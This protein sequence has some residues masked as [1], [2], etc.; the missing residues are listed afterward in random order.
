M[1]RGY[2]KLWRSCTDDDLYFLEPFTKWQAWIDLLILANHKPGMISVR[3]NL[4]QVDSGQVAVSE[5][6]VSK[7]WRW[8]RNK[9]RRFAKLLEKQGKMKQ[10]KSNVLSIYTITNWDIY[11]SNDTT[12]RRQK[13]GRKTTDEPH[14]RMYKNEE[15]IYKTPLTPHRGDDEAVA[16]QN[17]NKDLSPAEHTTKDPGPESTGLQKKCLTTNPE[18]PKTKR[19]KN[20][21]AAS[22][23]AGNQPGFEEVG[24]FFR[25]II[26][27]DNLE[28]DKTNG[29]CFVE[30]YLLK[31]EESEWIKMNGQPVKNWKLD[32]HTWVN[33]AVKRGEFKTKD[34]AR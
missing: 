16:F 23:Y 24:D 14:L 15:N 13:D 20:E 12:E 11:Q 6:F 1:N 22:K 19:K 8:S 31:R 18:K 26:K 32:F 21:P 28:V 4:I 29:R 9:F 17:G 30:N 10:Q 33:N 34:A 27:K 5:E 3:G 25:E 2:I 7:R